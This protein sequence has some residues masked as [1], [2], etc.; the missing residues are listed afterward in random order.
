M[1]CSAWVVIFILGFPLTISILLPIMEGK[2]CVA[3]SN[4]KCDD[5]DICILY[6]SLGA[7]QFGRGMVWEWGCL[8]AGQFGRVVVC[9]RGSL[10][11][12]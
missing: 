11:E 7:G 2:V 6:G 8:V 3:R 10:G 1:V 9:E 5:I 12:G 4:M